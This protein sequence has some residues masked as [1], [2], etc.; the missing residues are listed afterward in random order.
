MEFEEGGSSVL[1]PGGVE[2]RSLGRGVLGR[3]CGRRLG[4]CEAALGDGDEAF[5]SLRAEVEFRRRRH[6]PRFPRAVACATT[7]GRVGP[8]IRSRRLDEGRLA[9]L[10]L[11]P[12]DGRVG[13]RSDVGVVVVVVVGALEFDFVDTD[14]LGRLCR[15][16]G[17]GRCDASSQGRRGVAAVV[18]LEAE[19][20]VE[21][22]PIFFAESQRQEQPLEGHA[23]GLV[24][25]VLRRHR[26]PAADAV[27]GSRQ[28]LGLDTKRQE[29]PPGALEG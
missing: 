21:R 5:H 13:A 29:A 8:G 11:L 28:F 3:R 23:H 18:A 12:F 27:H 10:P 20:A 19:V 25:H 9:A 14:T 6:H 22:R 15:G 26:L 1:R 16:G 7:T 17:D 4:S 24:F 2:G